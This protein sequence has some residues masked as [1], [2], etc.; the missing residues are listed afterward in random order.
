M[1]PYTKPVE[2]KKPDTSEAE[3]NAEALWPTNQDIDAHNLKV[4]TMLELVQ[5]NQRLKE[6]VQELEKIKQ[7]KCPYCARRYFLTPD[8]QE[9]ADPYMKGE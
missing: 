2:S 4:T 1:K 3:E 8:G 5:R 9:V 6:R 7:I